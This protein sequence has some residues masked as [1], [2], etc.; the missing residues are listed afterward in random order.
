MPRIL[1]EVRR[2][3]GDARMPFVVMGVRIRSPPVRTATL[4]LVDTGSPYSGLSPKDV[5]KSRMRM[6]GQKGQ[7]I[8]LAGMMF[9]APVMEGATVS[10]RTEK[11]T[12]V[13]YEAEGFRAFVPTKKMDPKMER[14][15]QSIPSLVGTDLLEA[16]GI[17]LYFDPKANI[18]YLEIP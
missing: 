1:C 6:R 8:G 18:A 12:P 15:V 10:F 3:F 13:S 9:R 5:L 17:A 16:H 11:G 4:A 2:Q 7:S 14:E